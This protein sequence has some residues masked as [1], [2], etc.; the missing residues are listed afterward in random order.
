MYIVLLVIVSLVRK[1]CKWHDGDVKL[2]GSDRDQAV[3]MTPPNREG[4]VV[5][6]VI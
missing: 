2:R 6:S 1:Y 4:R 3:V 5:R